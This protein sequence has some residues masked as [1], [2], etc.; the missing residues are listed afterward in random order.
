M[1][2]VATNLPGEALTYTPPALSVS[3]AQIFKILSDKDRMGKS[4]FDNLSMH[5][6][7]NVMRG[8]K[9]GSV[10]L[11]L[12]A[13]GIGFRKNITGYYLS[14][15]DKKRGIKRGI[16]K[17][18]GVTIPAYLNDTPPLIAIQLAA[19]VGHVW[20][21]YRMKGMSGGLI[22]G[23]V[24]ASEEL[25]KRVPFYGQTARMAD[26]TRTPESSMIA[27]ADFLGSMFIPR[28]S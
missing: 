25:A 21:H 26:A 11:A 6:M 15:A 16:M 3:G 14:E 13:I 7:D 1:V 5:D 22:A 27:G 2:R 28:S 18:G 4:A 12:A 19:T 20:D 24:Q 8:L 10:G 23:A 17:I 9:K